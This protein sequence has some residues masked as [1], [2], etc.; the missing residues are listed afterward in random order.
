MRAN[1]VEQIGS[2]RQDLACV[3]KIGI[4]IKTV[5]SVSNNMLVQTA[6]FVHQVLLAH[7]RYASFQRQ[8][9]AWVANVFRLLRLVRPPAIIVQLL[10]LNARVATNHP[11]AGL[12]R[13]L[14]VIVAKMQSI[15]ILYISLL[16]TMLTGQ[17]KTHV[18]RSP[19]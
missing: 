11:N 14:S 10:K 2:V 12:S 9:S 1:L 6:M 17:F 8:V 3:L 7:I 16:A 18:V 4:Q 13:T 19:L 15:R 5:V